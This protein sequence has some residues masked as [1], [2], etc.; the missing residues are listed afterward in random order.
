MWAYSLDEEEE[1][2]KKATWREWSQEHGK[3]EWL[4]SAKARTKFYNKGKLLFENTSHNP[5]GAESRGARPLFMWKLVVR[6]GA[7]AI[8][9]RANRPRRWRQG[10]IC[11]KSLVGARSPSRQVCAVLSFILLEENLLN[12][13]QGRPTS[14]QRSL[15]IVWRSRTQP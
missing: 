9:R 1:E 10:A 4:K 8:R 3:D 14:G 5:D 12:R 11:R 15:D 6:G 13:A 2:K 7:F